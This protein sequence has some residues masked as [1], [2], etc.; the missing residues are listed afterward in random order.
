MNTVNLQLDYTNKS[1]KWTTNNSLS[2]RDSWLPTPGTVLKYDRFLLKNPGYLCFNNFQTELRYL[3]LS[4]GGTD[5][6]IFRRFSPDGSSQIGS[7]TISPTTGI[8]RGISRIPSSATQV[9]IY[10]AFGN[11]SI[12]YRSLAQ[13]GTVITTPFMNVTPAGLSMLS[14]IDIIRDDDN[15]DR[16]IYL[17]Q[18]II[19]G[20]TYNY[21]YADVSGV[22]RWTSTTLASGGGPPATTI[23]GELFKF[24]TVYEGGPGGLSI[25]IT[26]LSQRIVD[27]TWWIRT[28]QLALISGIPNIF[29]LGSAVQ[30]TFPSGAVTP[31]G[32]SVVYNLTTPTNSRLF[33]SFQ[34]NIV[35]Q[36]TVPPISPLAFIKS[37]GNIIASSEFGYFNNPIGIFTFRTE[38]TADL[39]PEFYVIESGNKRISRLTANLTTPWNYLSSWGTPVQSPSF[40]Q[41]VNI[42]PILSISATRGPVTKFVYVL[43]SDKTVYQYDTNGVYTG[44]KVSLASSNPKL[45]VAAVA[46]NGFYVL[47]YNGSNEIIMRAFN[48]SG[49]AVGV[50]LVFTSVITFDIGFNMAVNNFA[51]FDYVYFIVKDDVW[52]AIFDASTSNWLA[53]LIV[54]GPSLPPNKPRFVGIDFDPQTVDS[55]L[56]VVGEKP[57]NQVV[58]YIYSINGTSATLRSGTP[59]QIAPLSGG[60]ASANVDDYGRILFRAKTSTQLSV[61]EPIVPGNYAFSNYSVYSLGNVN[62]PST[63]GGYLATD[64]LGHTYI[65]ETAVVSS[66]ADANLNIYSFQIMSTLLDLGWNFDASLN[67]ANSKMERD[68]AFQA[69]DFAPPSNNLVAG[70][71]YNIV[72][73]PDV[74]TTSVITPTIR[75]KLNNIW[76]HSVR[77]FPANSAWNV[78][79][80]G[81]ATTEADFMSGFCCVAESTLVLTKEHGDLPIQD[82]HSGLHIWDVQQKG[83]VRVERNIRF[84]TPVRSGV[85]FSGRQGDLFILGD[86]PVLYR[87]NG[88]VAEKM[89]KELVGQPGV[90]NVTYDLPVHVHT[91]CTERRSFV[92]MQGQYAV[93][94]WS[95]LGWDNY[96][97]NDQK[98]ALLY[99]SQ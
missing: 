80:Q 17:L 57:G 65:T 94:T 58:V 77:P 68:T 43:N 2:T 54:S 26:V 61:Y 79:W 19:S 70:A 86:H 84:S 21:L 11:G 75:T 67:L 24:I 34:Q 95:E 81:A 83:W 72:R 4:T 38:G 52:A 97:D 71:C 93:G 53:G 74:G 13:P 76:M 8:Y 88:V 1:A 29:L 89:A 16:P 90:T 82:I 31:T 7:W 15:N 40:S 78:T 33:V 22:S 10:N 14:N 27:S 55:S 36:Y 42:L 63:L 20:Q 44:V 59:W 30:I 56:Y 73:D 91:L 87:E 49:V 98:R 5:P 64:N 48:S 6:A 25:F 69:T 3:D 85:L 39:K 99:T 92:L 66:N 18:E 28:F 32:I 60:L 45:V 41:V 12:E 50:P 47:D 96:C 51:N 37:Y 62:Q 35:A 46:Y 23:N 9:A